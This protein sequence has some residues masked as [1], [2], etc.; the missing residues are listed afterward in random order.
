MR[1]MSFYILIKVLE[2]DLVSYYFW[3]RNTRKN[4]AIIYCQIFMSSHLPADAL[5][6]EN[7]DI[8]VLDKL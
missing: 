2:M 1:C 5:L 4:G 7:D 3:G 6:A 8:V